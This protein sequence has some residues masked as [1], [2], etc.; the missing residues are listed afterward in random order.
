[1]TDDEI[2]A[3]IVS[4]E[5]GFSDNASDRGG[6]TN[7]GISA[8]ELGMWRKLRRPATTKE[9]RA[10]TEEEARKIYL[11]QYL[12]PFQGVPFDWLRAQLVD[13][14]VLQGTATAVRGL[15]TVLGVQVDGVI[16][17]RTKAA[18]LATN[19]KWVNNSLIAHRVKGFV[20]L[21]TKDVTQTV[22]F[23]GWVSRAV[24]F[25]VG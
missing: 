7:F 4:R 16:G 18:L 3:G 9:V 17:E 5:G 11:A 14:G 19:W 2:V 1:V 24:L 20:D 25:Y 6:S 21:V 13:F 8:R 12:P 23:K 10:L 15:Q 22:F